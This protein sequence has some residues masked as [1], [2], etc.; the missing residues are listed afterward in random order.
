M[1]DILNIFLVTYYYNFLGKKESN[2]HAERVT[3]CSYFGHRFA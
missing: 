1:L 2:Q 3:L